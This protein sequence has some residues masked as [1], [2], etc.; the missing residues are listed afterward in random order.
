ML[1]SHALRALRALAFAFLLSVAAGTDAHESSKYVQGLQDSLLAFSA[2]DFEAHGPRPDNFRN[3]DLRY[4]E[5]DH[6]ARSYMLCGQVQT[7]A[8]AKADWA[9]F[10]TIR[11]KPYEQWVGGSATDMCA[12]AVPVSPDGKDL[13]RALQIKV[14]GNSSAGES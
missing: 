2:S 9:D 14:R 13:S 10:A 4:R 12:R 8:G 7:G 6:G 11:T 3:V 1:T 5:N